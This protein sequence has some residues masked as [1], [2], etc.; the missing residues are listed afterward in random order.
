MCMCTCVCVFIM[1]VYHWRYTSSHVHIT[2]SDGTFSIGSCWENLPQQEKTRML[3]A[4]AFSGSQTTGSIY[5]KG[6]LS[7]YQKLTK[8]EVFEELFQSLHLPGNGLLNP[9]EVGFLGLKIMQVIY[10]N[11]GMNLTLGELRLKKFYSLTTKGALKPACLPPSAGAA[12]NHTLRAYCQ[13]IIWK[14]LRA[15][16][17]IDEYGFVDLGR[18]IIP[19]GTQEDIAPPMLL[20]MVACK[21]TLKTNCASAKCS[22]RSIGMHC[23]MACS[24]CNGSS[25]RNSVQQSEDPH[26]IQEQLM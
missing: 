2:T 23:I 10:G 14:N 6:K 9:D 7:L 12:K 3:F 25:C 16:I 4:H 8:E 21:C 18:E 13:Y 20:N 26:E 17:N 24:H 19:I 5:G 22:C 11:T 15:V 1:L